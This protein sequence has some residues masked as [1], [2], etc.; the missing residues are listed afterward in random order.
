MDKWF[1]KIKYICASIAIIIFIWMNLQVRSRD[2]GGSFPYRTRGPF[3]THEYYQL[4]EFE[5][6]ENFLEIPG[7]EQTASE[8][9]IEAKP[10]PPLKLTKPDA[11]LIADE[12]SET[13]E[14][15]ISEQE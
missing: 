13:V 1:P 8:L 9:L 12:I 6:W 11:P 10:I 15:N 4:S 3:A 2:F 7:L 5:E 14:P